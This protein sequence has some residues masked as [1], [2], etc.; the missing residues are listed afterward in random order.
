MAGIGI[1][2]NP[3]SK[4]NKRNPER[5]KLLSFIAGTRGKLE[6]TNNLEELRLV[7]RN[8][9]DKEIETI[10]INGGDG[11]ISR[12]ITAIIQEYQDTPIP[13]IAVLRGGTMNMLADNLGIK[14][15]PETNLYKLVQMHSLKPHLDL[16]ELSTLCVDGHYGFLF[17]N[18]S[19]VSFLEEF[20]KNKTNALGSIKLCTQVVLSFFAMRHLYHRV[21]KDGLF[22]LTGPDLGTDV[23]LYSPVIFCSTVEKIPLHIRAFRKLSEQ[24][25]PCFQCM[26]VLT[27]SHRVPFDLHKFIL[28]PS[29]DR[30]ERMDF[31][32]EEIT[33][34]S[35]Q[36]T[37]A[38]YTL[39]GE[40][41]YPKANSVKIS[42]GPKLQFIRI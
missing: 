40:L 19:A 23:T 35:L 2:T 24:T 5:S 14:G 37:S 10:A 11:T 21:I 8:F 13:P 42:L 18:G 7:A 41:Y 26:S 15:S 30:R 27:P 25:K 17:A 38:G 39:D 32:T 1:I 31:L 20:Y 22:K 34:E 16:Q 36:K 28:L 29:K 3:H 33:I 9:R 6:I 12:T 4:L